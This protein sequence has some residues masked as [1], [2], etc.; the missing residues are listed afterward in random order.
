MFKY[1]TKKRGQFA[2]TLTV[3]VMSV[4]GYIGWSFLLQLIVDIA[5]GKRNGSLVALGGFFV[6]YSI[7]MDTVGG[8]DRYLR[9][10]LK[11]QAV[12][13]ARADLMTHALALAPS[14]FAEVGVGTMIGK[15]TK[16]LDNVTE[17]F[18]GE[19]LWL[20]YISAQMLV[21]MIATLSI[22]P[23]I[24]LIILVMSVPSLLFPFALKKILNAASDAQVAAIDRY[25]A[26]ATDLLAGFDTIKF[27]LAGRSARREH[28]RVNNHLVQTQLRNTRIE[29]ISFGVST[30]LNDLTYIAAWF[31]GAI[32]VQRGA[33]DMGQMV[34]FSTL[35]GYLTFPMMSL[36]QD[37]PTMIGGM[38]AADKLAA[39]LK[40]PVSVETSASVV[41]LTQPLVSLDHAS[42]TLADQSVL[43]DLNLTLPP[44]A[45]VLV[46]GASGSGK[47]TL[48]RLVLGEI[49]PTSGRA[50]L[51]AQPA[52][53]LPRSSVYGEVGMLVQSGH[54]F[55]GTVR[56]N[57]SLFTQ[58]FSESQMTAAMTRAGLGEW[59]ARHG[60]DT[61]VSE[62]NPILSGGE[63]QRLAL[64][65]LYLRHYDYFVFDELTTGLDPHVA[66]GLLHDLFAMPQGFLLV[67]HTYDQAAFAAADM[68]VVMHGGQIIATGQ[69]TA[70]AVAA[71]LAELELTHEELAV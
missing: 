17:S 69:S 34:V 9:P 20:F 32:M 35:T 30:L 12:G 31:I 19:A 4:C 63:K 71:A 67:T 43:V 18:F 45:K 46:V 28:A 26:K 41:S 48:L 59:L 14:A 39:F 22:S 62:A 53:E 16:Q 1:L 55:E 57:L 10:R 6:L 7:V 2:L 21:A 54:I 51:F 38:R 13:W 65:R 27:A 29:A 50:D 3:A 68:I 61:A 58:A 49:A 52:S 44:T 8:T 66:A 47:T 15:L 11:L 70:P 60:L 56:E 64:A 37:I 36:T 23:L 25:T 24:T 40:T 5:T 42:Y 33:M